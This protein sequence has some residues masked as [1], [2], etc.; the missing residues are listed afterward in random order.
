[1]FI[2][3]ANH[4]LQATYCVNAAAAHGCFLPR[5]RS[6]PHVSYHL[7]H[8]GLIGLRG[9]ACFVLYTF[10][11][12]QFLRAIADLC[13]KYWWFF[14]NGRHCTVCYVEF[15]LALFI[16]YNQP[17]YQNRILSADSHTSKVSELETKQLSRMVSRVACF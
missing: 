2:K 3:K 9:K 16:K 10:L 8:G 17:Q 13:L 11:A 7:L 4:V 1:M 6:I 5:M 15:P 14:C 12:C